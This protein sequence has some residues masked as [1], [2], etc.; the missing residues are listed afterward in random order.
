MDEAA[1]VKISLALWLMLAGAALWACPV[2]CTITIVLICFLA[3]AP[4]FKM[5]RS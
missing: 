2:E 3:A 4:N 1:R 5:F